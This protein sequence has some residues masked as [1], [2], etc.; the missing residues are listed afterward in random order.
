[1]PAVM[2]RI[3]FHPC[4]TA[5]NRAAGRRGRGHQRHRAFPRATWRSS[6]AGT[7]DPRTGHREAGAGGRLRAGRAVAPP[8]ICAGSG[9]A[10]TCSRRTP[11][12]GMMRYGIPAYRL[13]R[14]VLA[15]EIARIVDLGVELEC[16]RT[17]TTCAASLTP[18]GYDAVFLAVGAAAARRIDIPAGTR[19]GYSTRSRSC[20]VWRRGTRRASAAGWWSTAV[21]TPPSMRPARPAGWAPQMPWSSTGGPGSACPPIRGAG[22]RPRRGGDRPVASTTVDNFAGPRTHGRADGA[23]R[24]RASRGPPARSRSSTPT[25]WCWPSDRTPTSRCWAGRPSAVAGRGVQG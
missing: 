9:H 7:P 1:M 4:E 15:A 14:E 19:P 18:G 21:A 5:C 3:C 2:G 25:R 23:G 13:P 17:V 24:G 16:G 20:T 8:T 10:V 6:G 22:G 11:A 12:G